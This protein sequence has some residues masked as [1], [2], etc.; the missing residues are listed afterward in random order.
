MLE[1]SWRKLKEARGIHKWQAD[2]PLF[3]HRTFSRSQPSS[4]DKRGTSSCI[5]RKTS[6][7][8]GIWR[9]RNDTMQSRRVVACVASTCYNSNG[10]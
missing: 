4:H 9:A 8:G 10:Y 6:L 7:E 3:L 5:L 2:G 1:G